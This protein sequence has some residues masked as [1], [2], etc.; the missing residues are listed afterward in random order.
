MTAKEAV[1]LFKNECFKTD[2]EWYRFAKRYCSRNC[3]TIVDDIAGQYKV[4]KSDV[5][6]ELIAEMKKT[7]NKVQAAVTCAANKNK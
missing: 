5:K 1:I 2:A 4:K 3:S 7:I 6:E